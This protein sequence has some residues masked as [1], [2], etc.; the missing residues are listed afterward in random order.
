MGFGAGI[1]VCGLRAST[2]SM[3]G[4]PANVGLRGSIGLAGAGSVGTSFLTVICGL[5]TSVLG[6]IVD[7]RVSIGFIGA[8]GLLLSTSVFD[9]GLGELNGLSADPGAAGPDPRPITGVLI[10]GA[11]PVPVPGAVPV[12][13]APGAVDTTIDG[14]TA[15]TVLKSGTRLVFVVDVLPPD[16]CPLPLKLVAL[17]PKPFSTSNCAKMLFGKIK[18][19]DKLQKVTILIQITFSMDKEGQSASSL[20]WKFREVF[21]FIEPSYFS[22]NKKGENFSPPHFY[23][24]VICTFTHLESNIL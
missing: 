6:C 16:G 17:F 13:P 15:D 18:K 8:G 4:P 21:C 5:G 2:G 22:P 7:L 12:D 19:Q 9:G 3:R 10:V 20:F 24:F 1:F 23:H 14:F 11:G